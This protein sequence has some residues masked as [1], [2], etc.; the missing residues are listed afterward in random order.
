MAEAT[1]D[2]FLRVE[3]RVGTI[4]EAE[5]FPE[6]RK[7]AIKLL[8]DLGPELGI[9]RSSA[10]ITRHYKPDQLIGRQV[11]VV[12]NLAP[13]QIG[14]FVSEVLTLG[15]PDEAGEVVLIRPDH[16]VPDGGRLY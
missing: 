9:R 12:A 14:P 16:E 6:A 10:Q 5:P 3:V 2:D 1:I 11:L 4:V 7:P 13:R 8:I 15:L